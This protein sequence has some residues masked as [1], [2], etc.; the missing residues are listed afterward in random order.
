MF[1]SGL[2]SI[3]FRDRSRDEVVNLCVQA[4]VKA[5]EWGGDVHVPHGDADAAAEARALCDAAGLECLSYGSYY[6]VGHSEDEGLSFDT[7]LKTAVTLKVACIRVWAG[8]KEDHQ[9]DDAYLKMIVEESRRIAALAATEQISIAYEF[10][11]GTLTNSNESALRL[12][13]AVD[14]PNVFIY[15]QPPYDGEAFDYAVEGIRM[16]KPWIYNIH[17]YYWHLLNAE[18][19]GADRRPLAEA[20]DKLA[21]Y[22]KECARA[23][24]R[25]AALIEFV[26]DGKPEQFLEDAEVLNNALKEAQEKNG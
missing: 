13:K 17:L 7:V 9:A 26:R 12:M 19:K 23:G 21:V 10:H 8:M 15:W 1:K 14:H 25:Q 24:I 20:S 6:R 11:C 3:T 22:V 16:L 2:C 4:G 18:T 5:I